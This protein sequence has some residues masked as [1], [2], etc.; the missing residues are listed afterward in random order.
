MENI[1]TAIIAAISAGAVSG[2]KDV[3]MKAIVDGYSALK[4][5]ITKRFGEK[6]EVS[7]AVSELESKPKSPGRQTTLAEEVQSAGAEND[8]DIVA[9][10]TALLEALEAQPGGTQYVQSARGNFIAQASDNSTATVTVS[11]YK[12]KD[13]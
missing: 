11:G 7:K 9:A 4:A 3:A 8:A 13:D 10:A 6:S 1:V 5:A 2:T 12:L